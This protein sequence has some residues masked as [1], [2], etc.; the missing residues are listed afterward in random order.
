MPIKKT[1]TKPTDETKPTKMSYAKTVSVESANVTLQ[2]S[3]ETTKPY[4]SKEVK[5]F[6]DN[7]SDN[8]SN[9]G[10]KKAVRKPGRTLLI[11]S[12]MGSTLNEST[13][14]N[15][16]GMTSSFSTKNG[17]YFLTFDT[18]EHS[19]EC[20]KKLRTEQPNL[21]VKFS[22]Y[23]IYFKING[24]TDTSDYSL[25]KQEISDFVEKQSGGSVLYFKLYRKGDK[26]LGCGDLTV[27]TKDAMDKLLNKDSPIKNYT[28]GSYSG[29]F[30]RFNKDNKQQRDGP[31][32]YSN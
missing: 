23:Q 6:V 8:M 26:F 24:L 7:N 13:L 21:K 27:D 18:I 9:D 28:V 22:R 19:L 3:Q 10:Q 30:F 11:S 32:M 14:T 1:T 16:E 31:K 20:Y 25:V 17:S 12:S 4:V 29:T 15:L 5:D 2:T